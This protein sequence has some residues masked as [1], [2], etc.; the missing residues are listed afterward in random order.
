MQSECSTNVKSTC[1][2]LPVHVALCTGYIPPYQLPVYQAIA[3]RLER[4]T[5]LVST[6]MERNR[7]WEV[8]WGGLDVI[9]QKTFTYAKRWKQ[10]GR[11]EDHGEAHVPLDTWRQLRRLQPDVLVSEELGFRSIQCALFQCFRSRMPFVLA[12][13]LS[14][15]T[16]AGRNLPRRMVRR[17]LAG[18]A[19]ATMVNGNSGRRY[20]ESTGFDPAS[21]F[22]FPY[23][24][25]A[26]AFLQ[27]SLQHPAAEATRIAVCGQLTERKG[28]PNLL[29]VLDTWSIANPSHT[30]ELTFIGNGPLEA[31]IKQTRPSA[32]LRLRVLGQL[33]YDEIAEVYQ[34]SSFLAFPTWADEW[35]LVVNE[36]LA[37]GLPVLG[38]VYSQAVDELIVEGENGWRFCPDDTAQFLL[39]LDTAIKTPERELQTM[40]AKARESI[41]QRTP[42]WAAQQFIEVIS[43]VCGKS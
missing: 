11:F 41:L 31:E 27:C 15:H 28:I 35:G 33:N 21:I 14:E 6:P 1:G 36:A 5:I 2:K 38:S 9:Q 32:N 8:D 37:A 12:C 40:R 23:I 24:A 7:Q 29:S 4:F 22:G 25:V 30:L 18:R 43:H 39:A 34:E 19:R 20:L 10:S 17:W 26:D 42:E 16:E 13:N 3:E